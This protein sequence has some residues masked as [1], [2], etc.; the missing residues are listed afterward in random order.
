MGL[1]PDKVINSAPSS[2]A[3]TAPSN[4]GPSMVKRRPSTALA[5]LGLRVAGLSREDWSK[6]EVKTSFSFLTQL[7]PGA[8]H[9]QANILHVLS[10]A[11]DNAHNLPLVE[12]GNAVAESKDF[13]QLGGN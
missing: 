8:G 1:E 13:V 3:I 4:D 9:H 12:N 2:K 5:E 10:I 6:E 7:W 11:G